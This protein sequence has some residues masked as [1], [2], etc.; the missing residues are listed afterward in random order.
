MDEKDHEKNIDAPG[1]LGNDQPQ[2]DGVEKKN[3]RMEDKSPRKLTLHDPIFD[4]S[5][6][7]ETKVQ[8]SPYM[9]SVHWSV[10]WSD[11]MMTMFVM[12][13]VLFAS[14]RNKRD[15]LDIF[16]PE[17]GS[18]VKTTM[19]KPKRGLSF[20]EF[21]LSPDR[22]FEISQQAVREAR[23]EDISVV[24]E[25][26]RTVRVSIRGPLLFDLGKA[27]L[28]SETREF[29]KKIAMVLRKTPNEI[30][31]VGHTDNF[32]ISNALFQTNWEL[33]A[34]R[35][36]RVARYLIESGDL[37]PGRFSILGHSMYRPVAPNTTE[38]NK[39]K[40]RRVEIIITRN[41]YTENPTR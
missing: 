23:L 37:K 6:F 22:L 24:L 31:V 39:Q 13:A 8:S 41:H 9:S 12:F 20:G 34:I 36:S 16:Q 30:H 4:F 3:L 2:E 33:S 38:E 14:L 26:D 18:E 15:L 21:E 7:D 29:L 19:M 5:D 11:L 10:P 17:V 1:K 28:R 25:E 35:A 32:P 40:N 27:E